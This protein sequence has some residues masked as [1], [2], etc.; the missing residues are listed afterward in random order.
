MVGAIAENFHAGSRS[1]YLAQYIFSSFGTA[2]AVP[3]HEDHGIDFFC[4]LTEKVGQLAWAKASYT[5][6]VKSDLNPWVFKDGRSVEWLLDHPLPLFLGVVDKNTTTLRI[7]HTA[8]RFYV[9][10]LGE[11]PNRLELIPTT[12]TVGKSTEPAL[13]YRFSLVPILAIDIAMLSDNDY[14]RNARNVLESWVEIESRNLTCIRAGLL[15][16]EM[17]YKFETNTLPSGGRVTQWLSR[18]SEEQLVHCIRHL[19]QCLEFVGSQLGATGNFVAA[20]EAALLHKYLHQTFTSMFPKSE[21]YEPGLL[22]M[23]VGALLD[24]LPSERRKYAYSGID[25][26]Q[27]RLDA[28]IKDAFTSADE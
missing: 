21:Y 1:E 20:V 13:D 8:P 12:E 25:D 10:G 9:W 18:P 7:Y 14:W 6:Q 27:E 19:S 11:H 16:W 4:T 5:V 24:K 17:P 15:G 23:F 26:I 22:A 3:H 2:V 28:A